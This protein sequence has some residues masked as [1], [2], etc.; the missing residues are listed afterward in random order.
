MGR[1]AMKPRRTTP[2]HPSQGQAPGGGRESRDGGPAQHHSACSPPLPP[3]PSLSAIA[4]PTPS[5]QHVDPESD[6][7]GDEEGPQDLGQGARSRAQAARGGHQGRAAGAQGTLQSR[8][9]GQHRPA[10]GQL[11]ALAAAGAATARADIRCPSAFL[12]LARAKSMPTAS[13]R[14]RSRRR[15]RP[16]TRSVDTSPPGWLEIPR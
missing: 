10:L 2:N 16:S 4:A 11:S 7:E 5:A 6:R 13:S 8:A 12:S 14:R 3:R 15:P 1:G 9:I